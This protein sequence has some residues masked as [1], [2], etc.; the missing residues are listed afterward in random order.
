MKPYIALIT[1]EKS[2]LNVQIAALLMAI[3]IEGLASFRTLKHNFLG[4]VETKLERRFIIMHTI[5]LLSNLMSGAYMER[6]IIA[7]AS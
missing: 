7:Y 4:I 5:L 1:C 6:N 3:G 2:T